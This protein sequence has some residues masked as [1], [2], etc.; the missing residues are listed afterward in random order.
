MTS[1]SRSSRTADGQASKPAK[2]RPLVL[3]L[4]P[5][6][7]IICLALAFFGR[8]VFT[9]RVLLPL[10]VL[11]LMVPWKFHAA[12]FPEFHL[13]QNPMLD[14]IQQYYPWRHFAVSTV[15]QGILPL[16]NPYAF[17]G[18][19]FIANLQSA[20]FYPPNLLFLILP[21]G[22]G[23]TATI[24]LHCAMAGLFMYWLLRTLDLTRL[25][26]LIGAVAFMFNGALVSWAEYPALGLWV[27]VWLPLILL[28]FEQA[29]RRKSPLLAIITGVCVA[30]QFLGGHLQYS[31]YVLAGFGIFVLWRLL[32]SQG[33]D[34]L[35]ALAYAL[36]SLT[37]GLGLAAAQ[38]LPAIELATRS[39]RPALSYAEAIKSALPATHLVTYFIPNFFG[40]P[41]AYNYWG[42]LAANRPGE[43]GLFMET[44]GYV[45]ILPLALAFA[46]IGLKRRGMPFFLAVAV[47]SILAALGTPVYGLLYYGIPGFKQLAGVARILYLAAFGIAG[48]AAMGAEGLIQQPARLWRWFWL[49]FPLATLLAVSYGL[50]RFSR[51]VAVL[52]GYATAQLAVL[53]AFLAL[54]VALI[55]LRRFARL[56]AAAFGAAAVA[57]VAADLFV[58]GWRFNP[59]NPRSMEYFSTPEV[60]ALQKY[61][62]GDRMLAVGTDSL[63]NWMPP[64]TPT[65]FRLQDIQ[66]SDSLLWG[67]YL[68]FLK[69]V[70]AE[71][72]TFQW[73]N[74]DSPALDLMAVRCVLTTREIAAPGLRKVYDGDAK[75]YRRETSR[76]RLSLLDSWQI[77]DDEEILSIAAQDRLE[78]RWHGLL[79]GPPRIR[80]ER[81]TAAGVARIVAETPNRVE[82]QAPL[83]GPRLLR[84]ADAAYPG[85]RVYIDGRRAEM[86]LCDYVFR[87]VAVPAGKHRVSFRYEPTSFRLGL[88]SSLLCLSL[89]AGA[90]PCSLRRRNA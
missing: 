56:P 17:C 68:R 77:A 73:S 66:G 9:G 75:V 36:A 81:V 23:F 48:L 38:L 14:P 85:W 3:R 44:C 39:Q 64:N 45:G 6:A 78:A 49:A 62:G 33:R 24:V 67:R 43:P 29:V 53:A 86:L 19:P 59:V 65:V 88:F 89:V 87:A 34:R 4:W 74:L 60:E 31:A 2:Q 72:P 35:R 13:A 10:D 70:N 21:I 30:M 41:T 79:S 50:T 57:I 55:A 32:A 83:P 22:L 90:L 37:I 54:A 51:D 63:K 7:L 84:L 18:T 40:N 12:N 20:V 15:K 58:F 61:T 8:A 46:S 11:L 1:G 71:A 69:A 16:W 76:T 28:V 25:A 82:I 27:M 5:H 42:H 26:A 52:A 80:V 47:L